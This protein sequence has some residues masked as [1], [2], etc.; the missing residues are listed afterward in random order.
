[1][2]HVICRQKLS[3]L[4]A[5]DVEDY[6]ENIAVNQ[7]IYVVFYLLDINTLIIYAYLHQSALHAEF[8]TQVTKSVSIA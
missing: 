8:T 6:I 1:M 5:S 4:N 2:C 7:L 3:L